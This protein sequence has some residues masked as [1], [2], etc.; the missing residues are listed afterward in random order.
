VGSQAAIRAMRAGN[1]RGHIINVSSV[2]AHSPSSGVYGA[3]KH[4]VNVISRTLRDEL[5][6]DQ[7]QITTVMPGLVATNIGRNVDP[8]LLEGVVA[9][10]GIEATIVPGERLPDEVLTKAQ[11]VLS[12]IMI[13]PEDVAEAVLFAVTQPEA[14]H[15]EEFVIRPHKDFPLG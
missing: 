4:A 5:L 6:E 13:R 8:A 11:S 12:E 1:R 10:S 7:I 2:A 9:M 3:T 15:I 14:V